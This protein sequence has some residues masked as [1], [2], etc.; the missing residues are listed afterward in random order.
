MNTSYD[1]SKDPFPL[2]T[3]IRLFD[4]T[5]FIRLSKEEGIDLN[6]LDEFGE[7]PIT[8]AIMEDIADIRWV[9]IL[10]KRGAEVNVLDSDGD[11]ALDLAR[12]KQREDL[13]ELLLKYGAKGKDEDSVKRK[14]LDAY[15][16]D[17]KVANFIKSLSRSHRN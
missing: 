2:N 14:N 9:R 3:S 7:T 10:L 1:Y 8:T 13:I 6:Q 15:Y 11:S 16:D 5:K 17:M 12:Y 4:T